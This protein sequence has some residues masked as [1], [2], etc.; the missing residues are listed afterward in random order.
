MLCPIPDCTEVSHHDSVRGLCERHHAI[1]Q[2]AWSSGK[3]T[4]EYHQ[5]VKHLH[6]WDH[7]EV[8]G[9]M[10]DG[11][12][13]LELRNCPTCHSTIAKEIVS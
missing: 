7:W 3:C 11:V 1:F 4:T 13:K 12:E 6:D 10:D 8:C 9:T 5:I 2:L